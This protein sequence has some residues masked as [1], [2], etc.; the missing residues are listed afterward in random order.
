MFLE[1]SSSVY[2]GPTLIG[3]C[4]PHHVSGLSCPPARAP[5][6]WTPTHVDAHLIQLRPLV[7]GRPPLPRH[8]SPSPRSG[9][10]PPR[11]TPADTG[12]LLPRWARCPPVWTPSSQAGGSH[13]SSANGFLTGTFRKGGKGEGAKNRRPE[14][15]NPSRK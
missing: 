12:T 9:S 15:L 5:P 10:S 4:P 14:S 6:S 1:W 8:G 2:R 11:W 13:L 3:Q 7:L